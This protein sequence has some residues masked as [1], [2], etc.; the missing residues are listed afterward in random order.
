MPWRAERYYAL[1]DILCQKIDWTR[2]RAK[3]NERIAYL[4]IQN[5]DLREAKKAQEIIR[6]WANVSRQNGDK[7]RVAFFMKDD[8]L[9]WKRLGNHTAAR[10][11]AES[12]LTV[13]KE[14]G[15]NK[16]VVEMNELIGSLTP[17]T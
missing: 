16:R 11:L 1:V 7:R 4:K 8:A 12:A 9:L 15:M 14:L 17:K 2:F 6:H 3:A 13:F 10:R 5:E